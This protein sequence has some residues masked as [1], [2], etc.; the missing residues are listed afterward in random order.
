MKLRINEGIEGNTI[1]DNIIA[2]VDS[3]IE[4]FKGYFTTK[5]EICGEGYVEVNI[6][7]TAYMD[8]Y[9]GLIQN[10]VVEYYDGFL[11]VADGRNVKKF[12]NLDEFE[13]FV[14]EELQ[15]YYDMSESTGDYYEPGYPE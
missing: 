3:V 7:E 11:N 9:Y 13:D 4:R 1:N 2:T 10:Y 15:D 14:Y 8:A 5:Y 12:N 6:Y